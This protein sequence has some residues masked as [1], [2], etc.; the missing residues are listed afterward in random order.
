[1]CGK[2][3]AGK[4]LTMLR[5]S[6]VRSSVCAVFLFALSFLR[7][8]SG[9]GGEHQ[10]LQNQDA[11]AQTSSNPAAASQT[12]SAGA[13]PVLVE[14]FTSEGCSSCPP[15]DIFLQQLDTTQPVPGAQLI[16]LSEHVTYWDHDGWKDPNSLAA[17]TDRQAAYETVLREPSSYT[18]QIIVDGGQAKGDAQQ[19]ADVIKKAADTPKVPVRIGE[20]TIAPGSP[21][22]LRVHV[23]TD[24]NSEKRGGDV[25]VAVAL[26]HVESQ[27]LK[28]EN[29]GKHLIHVA[30]VQQLA[31]VGKLAKGKAFSQDVQLK[32]APGTDPKNV[33]L[34]A[35]VQESGPGTVL[36]AAQRKPAI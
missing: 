12:A 27:V 30:V 22:V 1:V 14:L 10:P 3:A 25:Y 26:D 11:A 15:A 33:R 34:V 19:I 29:G 21:T 9:A 28:G 8:A 20:V 6:S 5:G 17:L 35:F 4:I 24:V 32:L 16:V 2:L 23:E 31:K 18:P 13:H 7:V 36:G